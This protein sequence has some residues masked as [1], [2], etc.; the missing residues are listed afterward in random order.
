MQFTHFFLSIFLFALENQLQSHSSAVQKKRENP[1]T[2]LTPRTA[3]GKR[4]G[5]DEGDVISILHVS[6]YTTH[7]FPLFCS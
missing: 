5:S 3:T 4:K 7:F 2:P 6:N 1:R